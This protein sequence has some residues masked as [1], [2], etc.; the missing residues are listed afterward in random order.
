LFLSAGSPL[1]AFKEAALTEITLALEPGLHARLADWAQEQ[2]RSL[3]AL[4][5]E[6]LAAAERVRE[7]YDP[8]MDRTTH[9]IR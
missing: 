5:T 8:T 9:G 4:V 7:N 1:P 6:I 2:D 3:P